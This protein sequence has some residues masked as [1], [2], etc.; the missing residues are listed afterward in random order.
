MHVAS[1]IAADAEVNTEAVGLLCE[2]M[3][4]MQ[5]QNGTVWPCPDI[6]VLPNQQHRGS[7]A[8]A[9]RSSASDIIASTTLEVVL[10]KQ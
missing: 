6:I 5:Y 1:D 10:Y 9:V 8:M 2:M 3:M 7:T 4:M